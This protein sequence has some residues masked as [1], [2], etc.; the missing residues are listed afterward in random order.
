[1]ARRGTLL[2]TVV[3]L[4]PI[5]DELFYRGALFTPLRK[6]GRVEMVILATAAFETLR[7]GVP[8][9]MMLVLVASLVFAWIRAATS[10]VLPSI[11]ARIAYM[12]VGALPVV[13][14]RDLPRPTGA[15]V[16]GSLATFVAGVLALA[17]LQ[18]RS[19]P[20]SASPADSS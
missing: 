19:A 20:G 7:S 17:M 3:F 8:R 10:S 1:M 5:M 13:F 12:A 15:W 2:V 11:F 4:Q 6:T 9:T 18:R 14:G 16:G